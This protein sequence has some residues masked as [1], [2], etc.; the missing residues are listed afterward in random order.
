[1]ILARSQLVVLAPDGKTMHLGI[2]YIE[3]TEIG[4]SE[5]KSLGPMFDREAWGIMRLSASV[6]GT[7][8]FDDYKSNDVIRISTLNLG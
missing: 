5:V 2:K 7:Y 6:K 1:M 4:W 8:V 3:R